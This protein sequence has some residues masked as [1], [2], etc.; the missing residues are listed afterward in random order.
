VVPDDGALVLEGLP[1]DERS[2]NR[3]QVQQLRAV[4]GKRSKA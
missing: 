2:I 1:R 3:V 4:D